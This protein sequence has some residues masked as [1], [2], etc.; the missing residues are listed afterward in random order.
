MKT[1]IILVLTAIM[2]FSVMAEEC[3][4][5]ESSWEVMGEL[6][7]DAGNKERTV[8]QETLGRQ[9]AVPVTRRLPPGVSIPKSRPHPFEDYQK[10]KP[11]YQSITVLNSTIPEVPE[12]SVFKSNTHG[13]KF[14]FNGYWL[15][16]DKTAT[17]FPNEFG[18]TMQKDW[19][20]WR[21]SNFLRGSI[22]SAQETSHNDGVVSFTTS[23][24]ISIRVVR[25]TCDPTPVDEP[26]SYPL[27]LTNDLYFIEF[28]APE[29]LDY[30][31]KEE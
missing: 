11:Q 19:Y 1:K 27:R 20:Q 14:F 9:P 3:V 31:K 4:E 22:R 13:I 2:S 29:Q 30:P 23:E 8:Y 16:L 24:G 25:Y 18:E 28:A 6:A 17:Y 7:S 12:G 10:D 5:I 15:Y 26:M 21:L